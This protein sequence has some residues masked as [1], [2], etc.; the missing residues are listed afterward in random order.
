MGRILR[1]VPA[2]DDRPRD[3]SGAADATWADALAPDDISALS[4]DVA[5]YHRELRRARRQQR[6]QR[7]LR[8]RGALPALVMAGATLLAAAVA[9]MLTL[10]APS[11]GD[12]PPTALPLAHP[13]VADGSLHGLLPPVSL[14]GPDGAAQ[15]QSLRP[16]VFALV[17]TKCGCGKL[18]D[19]LSGQAYSE[20]L[21]LAVVVPAASDSTAANLVS[22][23][24]RGAPDLY[25]DSVGAIAASVNARGVTLVAVSRDGT[26]YAIERGVTLTTANSL[27]ATLQSMLLPARSH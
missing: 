12:R 26:I 3:A 24:T 13:T 18:L 7:L 10:A 22:S 17:P 8:H 20:N 16:R 1:G 6:L 11:A 15:S 2:E 27:D 4:R 23:L 21:H 14:Q 25:F 19:T 5:A 9:V